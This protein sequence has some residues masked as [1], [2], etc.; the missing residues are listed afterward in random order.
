MDCLH[1][2]CSFSE[3]IIRIQPVHKQITQA[4]DAE[5]NEQNILDSIGCFL[6]PNAGCSYAFT[7]CGW[8]SKFRTLRPPTM[9]CTSRTSLIEWDASYI[10]MPDAPT[11]SI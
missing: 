11:H 1:V 6:H 4:S 7:Y 3:W 2:F 10:P 9:N 5:L 8:A